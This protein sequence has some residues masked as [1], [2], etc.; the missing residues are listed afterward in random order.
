MASIVGFLSARIHHVIVQWTDK[1]SGRI[2]HFHGESFVNLQGGGWIYRITIM[3]ILQRL[4][5][6][7]LI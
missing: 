5:G 4:K 7:H 2:T 6:Y 1:E 3:T